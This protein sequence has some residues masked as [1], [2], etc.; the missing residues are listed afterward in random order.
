MALDAGYS[1]YHFVQ[2]SDDKL[3]VMELN[4]HDLLR[5]IKTR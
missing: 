3:T 4:I 1:I 2:A 5:Q